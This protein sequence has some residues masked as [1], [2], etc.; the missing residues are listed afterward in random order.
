MLWFVVW[1]VLV[2][3]ALAALVLVGLRLWR[4]GKALLAELERAS[5]LAERLERRLAALEEAAPQLPVEAEIMLT[6]ER[7]DAL[8]AARADI[9]A[10][11]ATRRAIR[12][13]RAYGWWNRIGML[14]HERRPAPSG[15]VYTDPDTAPAGTRSGESAP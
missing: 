15:G 13:D 14:N 6:S 11:R 12:A 3:A 10:A 9:R 8:H 4:S 1:T 5:E 7:R 2:L